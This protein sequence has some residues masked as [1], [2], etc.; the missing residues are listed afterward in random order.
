MDIDDTGGGLRSRESFK[1][2]FAFVMVIPPI[3]LDAQIGLKN[4]QPHPLR[5]MSL[6][7]QVR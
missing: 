1:E 2:I 6:L 5:A 4:S 3:S 7:L